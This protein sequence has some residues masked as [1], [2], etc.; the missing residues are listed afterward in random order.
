MRKGR[1]TGKPSEKPFEMHRITYIN[2]RGTRIHTQKYGFTTENSGVVHSAKFLLVMDTPRGR[3]RRWGSPIEEKH[4][5]HPNPRLPH[6]SNDRYRNSHV[7][8]ECHNYPVTKH[9]SRVG[10]LTRAD[11]YYDHRE[12]I[13]VRLSSY[14]FDRTRFV[15]CSKLVPGGYQCQSMNF[16]HTNVLPENLNVT[17]TAWNQDSVQQYQKNASTSTLSLTG[18][19]RAAGPPQCGF[20]QGSFYF[21]ENQASI[22]SSKVE[23]KVQVCDEYK[24]RPELVIWQSQTGSSIH[25]SHVTKAPQGSKAQMK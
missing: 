22:V 16:K 14:Y 5:Y 18:N 1:I 19:E 25:G 11:N 20:T 2:P 23:A 13:C 12:R 3:S 6:P 10:R 24:R 21:R 15:S 8:W 17:N 4:R 9:I 7:L